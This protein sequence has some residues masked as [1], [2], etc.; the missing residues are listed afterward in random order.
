MRILGALGL[1]YIGLSVCVEVQQAARPVEVH[2]E[3]HHAAKEPRL[4]TEEAQPA[5][6][7]TGEAAKEAKEA[8]LRKE[9]AVGIDLGTTY[10]CVFVYPKDASSPRLLYI[11][12]YETMPSVVYMK[13]MRD[14]SG[15]VSF[16][17]IVGRPA[18][19]EYNIEKKANYYFSNFKR[20][21]GI[22]ELSDITS[23][24]DKLKEH[25]NY[26][27]LSKTING[28]KKV[29]FQIVHNGKVAKEITPED[30]SA[31]VLKKIYDV[32]AKEY[33]V[34]K[35]VVTVPAYFDPNRRA[36]T[37]LAAEVAGF[38][39]PEIREEP[40]AAAYAHQY[41][42]RILNYNKD[43]KVFVFDL[44]G[45]TFD[46][47]VV[48]AG[49]DVLDVTA[50]VGDNYL[51][52]EN[53]NDNLTDYFKSVIS[54]E[55]KYDI[56]KN[57]DDQLRLRNLVEEMKR[58]LC[59]KVNESDIK[60]GHQVS[61]EFLYDGVN[62][63]EL[64]LSIEKFNEFNKEFY[65]R[66]MSKLTGADGILG[67][68]DK[69]K[70]D[71]STVT[72]VLLVGGSTR[73]PHIRRMVGDIFG[74]KKI[75]TDGVDAD[76][77]VARGACLLAAY[78]A[79]FLG[80]SKQVIL[81][82][83]VNLSLGICVNENTFETMIKK[84]STIPAENKREFTTAEN[85]QTV[86]RIKVAQGERARFSDNIHL[87][88][89]ELELAGNQPRGVPRIEITVGIDEN[90][91]IS[92]KAQ[93]MDTKKEKKVTFDARV[94][95]VSPEDFNEMQKN[96][97][98]YAQQ[99]RE[100]TERV[101]AVSS[102]QAVLDSASKQLSAASV[103]EDIKNKAEAMIEKVKMW[104]ERNKNDASKSEIDSKS[105]EFTQEFAALLEPPAAVPEAKEA[106][107]EEL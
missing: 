74:V 19:H 49:E 45:G 94:A 102:L 28:K 57:A 22:G 67:L 47:S 43:E 73:I 60:T 15:N 69:N 91:N 31:L 44:G 95:R 66:I 100:F 27:I 2:P 98:L 89:F 41:D 86:V 48:E 46:V 80:E 92:V 18:I 77:I 84:G 9:A 64:T 25:A 82:D 68:D 42:M 34:S 52:G 78:S 50:K 97:E 13:E 17:P 3:T 65:A 14:A 37:A 85:N 83:S 54:D 71:S 16:G 20:G 76:T 62:A 72:R 7:T 32:V 35:L 36:A 1:L 6:E 55:K 24:V 26:P 4:E 56:S 40:V 99:D 105:S 61:E 103:P 39:K 90:G 107:R 8:K 70:V 81:I 10:S 23:K 93:D 88:H 30:L 12:N 51:G 75:Y 87:G 29:V 63:I 38:P 104:L 96:A 11:D 58:R 79:G 59:D 53:A 101:H 5:V 106:G 21:M 33:I